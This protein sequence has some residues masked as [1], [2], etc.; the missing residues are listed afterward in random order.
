MTWRIVDISEPGRYLHTEQKSLVV[1]DNKKELGRIP[2][3]DIQAIIAHS[4]Y[5]TYSHGLL[6]KLAECNIPLVVCNEKHVPVALLVP[7]ANHYL[8]SGRIQA[9]AAVAKPI[10][11]RIWKE[12][13][14][15]KIREQSRTLNEI[16]RPASKFLLSLEKK[17]RSGDPQNVEAQA[18]RYYWKKLF[19]VDFHRDRHIPG[20]N[21]HLN[22][23]YTILRSALARAV[24]S[25]GLSPSLGVGHINS[26]NNFCLV[27]DLLEP[28]RPLVDR[29]VWQNRNTWS[30]DISKHSK[31]ILAGLMQR[32][33]ILESGETDLFRAMVLVVNSLISVF[34]NSDKQLELPLKIE[35][36]DQ[37]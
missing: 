14:R 3:R 11:K 36:A 1:L 17:V 7:T 26:R 9:Q 16:D 28:F 23:G 21:A 24:I 5:G 33:L 10:K 34:E 15:A 18:A 35:F 32:T 19:G 31:E 12:L 13:V 37:S 25:A 4:Y 30:E 2:L 22:Y 6:F 29:V 8:Q 20:I 27:D